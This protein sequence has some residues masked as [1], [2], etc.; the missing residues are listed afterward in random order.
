[1]ASHSDMSDYLKKLANPNSFRPGAW[2]VIHIL[3]YRAKTNEEKQCF[4][5]TMEKICD[6]LKCG[7][8]KPHCIAYQKEHPISRYWNVKDENGQDIGMFKWSWAFHNAV[9]SRLGKPIMDF[10]TAYDLYSDMPEMFCKKDC[11]LDAN[12]KEM[13]KPKKKTP[14]V[15]SYVASPSSSSLRTP[16]ELTDINPLFSRVHKSSK[17]KSSHYKTSRIK[18]YHRRR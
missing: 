15:I 5:K 18:P 4:I 17:H 2:L 3:A 12:G 1:M 6:G 8:C 9:N 13:D 7:T 11:H 14:T 16:L 10:K